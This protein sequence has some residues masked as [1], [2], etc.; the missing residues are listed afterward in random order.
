MMVTV[1]LPVFFVFEA[2]HGADTGVS[3]ENG[4]VVEPHGYGNS[5]T[6]GPVTVWLLMS[7]NESPTAG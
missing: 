5:P 2:M 6:A 3:F 7:W 4:F 1:P